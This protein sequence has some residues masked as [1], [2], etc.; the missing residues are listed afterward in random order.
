MAKIEKVKG[1]A[2][3]GR[4]KAGPAA[5]P[6]FLSAVLLGPHKPPLVPGDPCGAAR[7]SRPRGCIRQ[8]T[9]G[10]L[11]RWPA[12]E[13]SNSQRRQ[14]S[15]TV[16]PAGQPPKRSRPAVGVAQAVGRHKKAPP[17]TGDSSGAK[18][19]VGHIRNLAHC[20]TTNKFGPLKSVTQADSVG[21]RRLPG[22]FTLPRVKRPPS[23]LDVLAFR[24]TPAKPGR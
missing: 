6:A 23:R 20:R 9:R 18:V 22:A 12:T 8:A 16:S 7:A 2:G 4:G 3:L 17:G 15:Y 11:Y 1:C 13:R 10:R 14:P 19:G 24:P 21:R 5:L